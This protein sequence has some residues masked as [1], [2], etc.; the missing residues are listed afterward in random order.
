MYIY[1]VREG[2][3]ARRIIGSDSDTG[4]RSV[5]R[6]HQTVLDLLMGRRRVRPKRIPRCRA[7]RLRRRRSLQRVGVA[8]DR[9]CRDVPAAVCQLVSGRSA[10]PHS[11]F[12]RR[13]R[14]IRSDRQSG[15]KCGWHP[16]GSEISQPD[17]LATDLE[18]HR[19]AP[20]SP[21]PAATPTWS[22]VSNYATAPSASTRWHGRHP[23]PRRPVGRLVAELVPGRDA[24]RVSAQSDIR[25]R[26]PGDPWGG[27]GRRVRGK[28]LLAS[29]FLSNHGIG[30]VWSPA[31][32]GSSISVSATGTQP[33]PR[34]RV[35]SSMRSS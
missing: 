21:S 11:A 10:G 19:T 30:P 25:Q 13:L 29:G 31:G 22:P 33:R 35:A 15:A 27:R 1:L 8:A 12:P 2:E 20:S 14:S 28:H 34:R 17:L 26:G 6:S 18:W 16:R 32:T 3:S 7:R 24:D 9:R 23:D 4:T 5:R